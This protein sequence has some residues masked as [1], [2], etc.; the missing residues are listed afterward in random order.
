MTYGLGVLQTSFAF[1][2]HRLGVIDS[3]LFT[4]EQGLRLMP[5]VEQP[6]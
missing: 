1:P 4:N 2:M 6:T 5:L 3:P